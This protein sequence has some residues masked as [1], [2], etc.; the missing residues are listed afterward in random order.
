VT[1]NPLRQTEGVGSRWQRVARERREA[2]EENVKEFPSPPT[3]ADFASP[4]YRGLGTADLALA[5]TSTLAQR[6]AA[7][8]SITDL[9]IH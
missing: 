1:I 3:T 2:D 7:Y 4:W 5:P 6:G 8:A 9:E